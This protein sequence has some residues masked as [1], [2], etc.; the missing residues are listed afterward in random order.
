MRIGAEQQSPHTEIYIPGCA[1]SPALPI[2]LHCPYSKSQN[3]LNTILITRIQTTCLTTIHSSTALIGD[4][5]QTDTM[6]LPQAIAV[7]SLLA[8]GAMAGCRRDENLCKS[9][10]LSIQKGHT[11]GW[12][13]DLEDDL[14]C[15]TTC[16]VTGARQ[17]ANGF[18]KPIFCCAPC[19]SV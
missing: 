13:C 4:F 5:S 19:T 12:E 11:I 10:V 1:L 18:M 16:D 6:Q 8:V 7:F 17:D 3:P 14:P 9:D 2:R 15:M